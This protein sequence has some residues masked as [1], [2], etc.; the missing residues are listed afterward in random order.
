MISQEMQAD[1]LKYIS[2]VH[3]AVGKQLIMG[4]SKDIDLYMSQAPSVVMAQLLADYP[5]IQKNLR[6]LFDLMNLMILE[7]TYAYKI[8]L[9]IHQL[10]EITGSVQADVLSENALFSV[11][12]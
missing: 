2:I 7:E 4:D 6:S 11:S 5:A 1:V 10:S 12:L 8:G 3:S 9:Y